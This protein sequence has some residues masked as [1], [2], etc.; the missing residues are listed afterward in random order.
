MTDSGSYERP[1]LFGLLAFQNEFVSHAEL[2]KAFSTWIADKSKTLDQILVEQGAISEED[3]QLFSRLVEKHSA[4]FGGDARQSLCNLSEL[5]SI[6]AELENLAASD[7]IALNTL[8]QVPAHRVH[9]ST[10]Q[11]ILTSRRL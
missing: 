9:A 7:P 11:T 2:L 3:R 5:G 1:L 8:S 10:Y 4:K 6:R